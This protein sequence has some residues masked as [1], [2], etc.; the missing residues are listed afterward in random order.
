MMGDVVDDPVPLDGR[1][2]LGWAEDL[3]TRLCHDLAGMAAT[4]SGTLEM[5]LE[6][7]GGE[8]AALAQEAASVLAARLRLFR[9]SWG[10][11]DLEQ[12]TLAGLAQGLPGRAKLSLDLAGLDAALGDEGKRLVL[13]LLLAAC[14]GMPF[15]GTITGSPVA[16]GGFRLTIGGRQAAWPAAV[17]NTAGPWVTEGGARAL[18]ATLAALAG[19]GLGWRLTLDGAAVTAAPG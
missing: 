13:C 14:A 6:D 4:L 17:A 12:A 15:G 16:G 10:G 9:A 11:G 7:G 2:L 3:T 18:A 1:V 8:A 19:S 5:V